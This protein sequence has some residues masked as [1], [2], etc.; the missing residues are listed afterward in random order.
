MTDNTNNQ[1]TQIANEIALINKPR[2]VRIPREINNN[3]VVFMDVTVNGKYYGRLTFELYPDTPLTSNNF[4]ALCTGEM[5]VSSTSGK[6]LHYKD[7]KFHKIYS[8]YIIQGGDYTRGDGRRGDSIYP[9]NYFTDENFIHEHAG[10]GTLAM[11]NCIGVENTN[12]SQFFISLCQEPLRHLDG[13]NVVFG[14][15]KSGAEIL[16]E[17]NKLGDPVSGVPKAEIMISDCGL[18]EKPQPRIVEETLE[19]NMKTDESQPSFNLENL[20]FEMIEKDEILY[21]IGNMKFEKEEH[22]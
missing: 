1:P 13:K 20:K 10:A 9:E 12:T 6:A 2:F 17:L 19:S 22:T 4:K 18:C 8:D 7:S 5:G 21:N 15:L 16:Q 11:V 14:R 3:D